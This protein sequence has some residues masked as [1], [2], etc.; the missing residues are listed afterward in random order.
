MLKRTLMMAALGAG[1]L[2]PA[3]GRASTDT[4]SGDITI[5]AT[6]ETYFEWDSTNVL[7]IDKD[8]DWTGG[9]GQVVGHMAKPG[10]VIQT[11]KVL[12]VNTNVDPVFHIT[13]VTH[14]G[15]L[16]EAGTTTLKTS[17]KL[18]T[19]TSGTIAASTAGF[20]DAQ[21]LGAAS[22]FDSGNF[23]TL[24]HNV[25]GQSNL[26]LEVKA[27]IPAGTTVPKA[28]DY[29]CKVKITATWS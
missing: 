3:F 23:W 25:A 28:A 14:G 2:I 8:A 10:D 18:S 11:V 9:H 13:A 29:T 19:A 17:Y 21:G 1:L 7:T 26:N 24:T 20:L 16:T 4:D 12:T 22:A 5:T 6:V 15:V 27:E